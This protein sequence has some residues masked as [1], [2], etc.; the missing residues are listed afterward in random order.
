M[1]DFFCIFPKIFPHPVEPADR[2]QKDGPQ[3]SRQIS[4]PSAQQKGCPAQHQEI[5]NASQR[6]SGHQIDPYH[7]IPRRHRIG[8]KRRRGQGPVYQVQHRP[9]SSPA[10]AAP[11][12]TEQIVDDPQSAP[13]RHRPQKGQSLAGH[14]DPHGPSQPA[15]QKAAPSPAEFLIG[16]GLHRPLYLQVSPV[17]AQLFDVKVFPPDD[18]YPLGGIHDNGVFIKALHLLHPGDG[19]P[20]PI[21]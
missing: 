10:Q 9:Q 18:Q 17:Q 3:K 11:K 13:Q 14:R 8:K 15:G 19:E 2:A 12:K 7:P 21:L 4:H 20:F 5:E 16:E 6:H 1:E